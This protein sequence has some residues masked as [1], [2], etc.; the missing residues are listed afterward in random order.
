LT[1][2]LLDIHTIQ[3]RRRSLR[4]QRRIIFSAQGVMSDTKSQLQKTGYSVLSAKDGGTSNVLHLKDRSHLNAAFAKRLP[5][6][7]ALR[8]LRSLGTKVCACDM[9]LFFCNFTWQEYLY[10][11]VLL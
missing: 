3:E 7:D 10:V 4:W 11:L 2:L 9:F 6:G 5:L 8:T 1:G